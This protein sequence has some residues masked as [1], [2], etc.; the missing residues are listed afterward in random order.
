MRNKLKLVFFVFCC[1]VGLTTLMFV[2]TTPKMV[3]TILLHV[4]NE[5]NLVVGPEA[6]R[7]NRSWDGQVQ[8]GIPAVLINLSRNETANVTDWVSRL[9]R[10]MCPDSPDLLEIPLTFPDVLLI[11]DFNSPNLYSVIPY[12]ELLYR[13]HFADI[14]YCGDGLETLKDIIVQKNI[15]FPVNF[16]H[17]SNHAWQMKYRCLE[18]AMKMCGDYKGYLLIG[19]DT[20]VNVKT[21]RALGEDR[22]LLGK[23][24][25]RW[26]V[27][28][29]QFK[30]SWMWWGNEGG[31]NA[32]LG[33]LNEL[34][35]R[36][37]HE[38]DVFAKQF[39]HRYYTF[40]NSST[41]FYRVATDFVYVPTR[42]APFFIYMTSLFRKYGANIE[43]AM[44][45]FACGLAHPNDIV[46][47]NEQDLWGGN[48]GKAVQL[49]TSDILYLHPF[50]YG[51]DFK[52]PAG[53]EFICKKYLRER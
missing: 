40:I 39:L 26:V 53:Q 23:D 32:M 33:V 31:R 4:E 6:C 35:Y 16:L 28:T 38:H 22:V 15:T 30:S 8:L 43:L 45:F 52:T 13:R 27:N 21:L 41:I 36:A 42:L 11:V 46:L 25:L 34:V 14:L 49:F 20:L 19:D 44:P 24:F 47:A 12:L 51:T 2:W 48:R 10:D 18:Y 5:A 7:M 1:V 9:H 50:K 29:T 3:S 37:V 17:I